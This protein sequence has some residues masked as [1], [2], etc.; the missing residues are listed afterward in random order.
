MFVSQFIQYVKNE[1][2]YSP[3]TIKAYK[4]DLEQFYDFID[5]TFDIQEIEKM[6]A[7]HIREWIV[8][9]MDRGANAA[10]V[11]R[12]ITTLKSYYK[13]LFRIEIL[14]KNPMIKIV[15][16]KVEKKIPS[17]Y[18]EVEMERLLDQIE[19]PDDFEGKRDRLILEL[20]YGTGMRLSEL[21][22][23]KLGDLSVPEQKVKVLGKR[24]KERMVPIHK[25]IIDCYAEYLPLREEVRLL[26]KEPYLLLTKGGKKLYSKLV[27]KQVN[28][29][30]TVVSSLEKRSP[31]VL[32]HTFATHMLNK[33][34][35]LNTIKE[36]LGHAN[37]SATQVYTHNSIEKLKEVYKQ[38]HPKS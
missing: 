23:L 29:Y 4:I 2:R 26:E 38:A 6:D 15:G 28:M 17:F 25:K 36:M 35:D 7:I 10:S 30:L 8:A 14:N 9:M 19:Y 13:F 18:K 33:G 31:H 11:N 3:H 24:N 1:K 12:K 5:Y 37:L 20:F 22:N 16:P 32:R 27:Y 34:A 21:I